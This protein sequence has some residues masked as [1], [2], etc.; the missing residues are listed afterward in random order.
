M[1]HGTASF[2]HTGFLHFPFSV[3]PFILFF[4]NSERFLATLSC[5]KLMGIMCDDGCMALSI[6]M[7]EVKYISNKHCNV[8]SLFCGGRQANG[9]SIRM[10]CRCVKIEFNVKCTLLYWI[11]IDLGALFLTLTFFIHLLFLSFCGFSSFFPFPHFSRYPSDIVLL[12]R[13]IIFIFMILLHFFHFGKFTF[14]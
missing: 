3:S 8:C 6:H 2:I 12:I 9:I 14:K 10:F 11:C 13:K 7:H 5:I 4:C 1:W